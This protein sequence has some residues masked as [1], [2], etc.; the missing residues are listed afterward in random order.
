MEIKLRVYYNAYDMV[1][2]MHYEKMVIIDLNNMD[3][4]EAETLIKAHRK[5]QFTGLKDKNGKDIY[6]G[7]KIQWLRKQSYH[8]FKKGDVSVIKW[9]SEGQYTG[10][11]FS[12]DK[13]LTAKKSKELEVIGNIHET[14]ELL[15]RRSQNNDAI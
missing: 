11:G 6:V 5:E 8:T 9:F 10:F 15:E 2:N 14:Q 13:P 3:L 7:D 4:E 1:K 12:P